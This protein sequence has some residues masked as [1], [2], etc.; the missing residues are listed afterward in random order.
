[1]LSFSFS[2]L[3]GLETSLEPCVPNE[4]FAQTGKASVQK[5]K[6]KSVLEKALSW[7]YGSVATTLEGLFS[8][9]FF[10]LNNGA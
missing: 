5:K 8:F 2:P 10:F 9:F 6:K 4:L 1:M 7:G 3:S